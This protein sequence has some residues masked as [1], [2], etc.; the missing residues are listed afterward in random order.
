MSFFIK[1][2]QFVPS[3]A[4]LDQEH[5][6]VNRWVEFDWWISIGRSAD[7]L[8]HHIDTPVSSFF[9][10][11]TDQKPVWP[12]TDWCDLTHLITAVCSAKRETVVWII[13]A[14]FTVIHQ[15]SGCH[16]NSNTSD[17]GFCSRN[18]CCRWM[19]VGS[20]WRPVGWLQWHVDCGETFLS[21]SVLGHK[22]ARWRSCDK[23]I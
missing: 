8:R 12:V 6:D 11:D 17:S 15:H 9:F 14:S 21:N 13:S 22:P 16:G 5:C 7:W 19:S 4:V 2:L 3:D 10:L 20:W 23:T 1:T 18:I